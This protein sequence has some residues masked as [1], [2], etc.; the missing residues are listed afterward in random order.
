MKPW[1]LEVNCLPSLSSS[2]MFDKQVKTQLICDT[3]TLIGIRGFDKNQMREQKE[4]RI[5]KGAELVEEAPVFKQTMTLAELEALGGCLIQKKA[6]PEWTAKQFQEAFDNSED[7]NLIFD[8]KIIHD[9][10]QKVGPG[11]GFSGDELLS[12]D[13]LNLI[14]DL[15]D[16]L[17]RLG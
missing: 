8:D 7:P 6:D 10:S 16:E 3:F 17:N 11:D 4:E 9:D 14:L 2:S 13:E 15:E 1:V 12:K 5:K